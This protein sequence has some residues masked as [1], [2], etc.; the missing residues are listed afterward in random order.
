[1]ANPTPGPWTPDGCVV[2]TDNG[3]DVAVTGDGMIFNFDPTR[4]VGEANA[5]L[6]AAAPDLLEACEANE[7]L[8]RLIYCVSQAQ[9]PEVTEICIRHS[10]SRDSDAPAAINELRS[11]AET[12]TRLAIAKAH[13]EPS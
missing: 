11:I 4:E 2:E 3:F 5:R 9:W 6:V 1:M 13:G 8:R 7:D 12:K 10:I